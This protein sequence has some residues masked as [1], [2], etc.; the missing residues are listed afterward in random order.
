[1]YHYFERFVPTSA[2][3]QPGE[4]PGSEESER[5]DLRQLAISSGR[6]G[7]LWHGGGGERGEKLDFH[8]I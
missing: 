6:C 5:Q 2:P 4:V 3:S 8:L 1:M 7:T